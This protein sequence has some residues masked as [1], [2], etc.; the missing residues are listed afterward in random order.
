MS[1]IVQPSAGTHADTWQLSGADGQTRCVAP[2]AHT[3]A[4]QVSAIEHWLP[5][6]HGVPSGA[7]TSLTQ[8]PPPQWP[9]A[10]Q[11]SLQGVPSA[12]PLQAPTDA[13]ARPASNSDEDKTK[14]ATQVL[15]SAPHG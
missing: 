7:I 12:R 10:M 11:V 3:P 15:I 4:W 9:D 13:A 8:A 6:L 1:V 5:E 14:S 2:G